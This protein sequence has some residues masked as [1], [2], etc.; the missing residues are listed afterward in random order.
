MLK[1][2]GR[3]LSLQAYEIESYARHVTDYPGVVAGLR[4]KSLPRT[5]CDFF[6][7]GSSDGHLTRKDISNVSLRVLSCG[8]EVLQG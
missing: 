2:R 8:I 7:I 4:L 5:D 1:S 3:L 6:A